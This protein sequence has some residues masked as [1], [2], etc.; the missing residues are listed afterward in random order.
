MVK[1]PAALK[2]YWDEVDRQLDAFRGKFKE[3]LARE[4]ALQSVHNQDVEAYGVHNPASPVVA[5]D[6]IEQWVQTVH[7]YASNSV[8]S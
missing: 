6:R 8:R 1:Y 5:S 7:D 4:N 3:K 2:V